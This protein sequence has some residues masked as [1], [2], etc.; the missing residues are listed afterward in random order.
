MGFQIKEVRH[1]PELFFHQGWVCLKYAM[2]YKTLSCKI[3]KIQKTLHVTGTE[4]SLDKEEHWLSGY[5]FSMYCPFENRFF[6]RQFTSFLSARLDLQ[7]MGRDTRRMAKIRQTGGK[8]KFIVY[9]KDWSTIRADYFAKISQTFEDFCSGLNALLEKCSPG[10]FKPL[11]LDI[12]NFWSRSQAEALSAARV[13]EVDI[14]KLGR[15]LTEG[16]HSAYSELLYLRVRPSFD[17]RHCLK[18]TLYNVFSPVN[19]VYELIKNIRREIYKNN[20]KLK[21]VSK[22]LTPGHDQD[23]PEGQ[24][25]GRFSG[26]A[27][28]ERVGSQA[29]LPGLYRG[30][31]EADESVPNQE[32]RAVARRV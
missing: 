8:F 3:Y 13:F 22:E 27:A 18:F 31:G 9:C 6:Q 14:S 25:P 32:H 7:L 15:S 21:R 24:L 28:G 26:A 10:A 20:L 23:L 30:I 19:K 5:K 29:G 4:Y 1:T 16:A 2:N 12:Q 11:K 17:P